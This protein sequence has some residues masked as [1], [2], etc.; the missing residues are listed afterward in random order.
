MYSYE[1]CSR[2]YQDNYT[3]DEIVFEVLR[4]IIRDYDIDDFKTVCDCMPELI[5]QKCIDLLYN[6]CLEN[7][8]MW[9]AQW[10][11]DHMATDVSYDPY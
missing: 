4:E 2:C 11:V 1:E 5:D 9:T 6:D 7:D 8:D 10:L 3:R